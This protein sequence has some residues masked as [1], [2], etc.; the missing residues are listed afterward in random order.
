VKWPA[1]F[2]AMVTPFDTNGRLATEEAARLAAWLVRHGT[3]G[4][5]VAGSTG[6]GATLT[7]D[8][9][10]RLF[11]AVREAVGP[12]VPIVVGTGTNDTAVSIERSRAAEKW[13]ADGV[14][15]VAPYYNKPPQAGLEAH[16][17]AIA[18]AIGIPVMLYNV[19]SRTSVSVEPRTVARVMGRAA[20]VLAV[21]ESSGNVDLFS[22]LV[23]QIPS[24]RLVYSGD[25]ILTLPALAVGA[26]GVVSVAS[27]LVGDELAA[28]IEAYG[29]GDVKTAGELHRRLAPVF[30]AL[31]VQSNPIPLKWALNR[32]GAAVGMPRLP[33]VAADDAAMR[34]LAEALE[35]A[36]VKPIRY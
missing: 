28:M 12:D 23:E 16:F 35:A 9:R 22:Q 17:L 5:V 18:G 7:D 19:P 34:P 24:D 3:G 11:R 2:T 30:R 10:E 33:L 31:F 25:D 8:E 4:L 15:A 13:G 27:H 29:R 6:E 21:K 1:V 26:V 14:L 36:G 32:L 20:N